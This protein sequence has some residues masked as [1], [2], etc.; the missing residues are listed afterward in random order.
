M[1]ELEP[2]AY[3]CIRPLASGPHLAL[4]VDAVAAGN[5]PAMAWC[6]DAA[7]PSAAFLWDKAHCYFLLGEPHDDAFNRSVRKLVRD[8]L[9]PQAVAHGHA[10][11][12]VY[13]G[14]EGW[15]DQI[16]ELFA[17][18]DLAERERVFQVL[19][20]VAILDWRKRVPDGYDVRQIDQRLL[21]AAG[22]R[23]ATGLVYEIETGWPSLAHFLRAGFGFCLLGAGEI[24][25][26][27]TAE[28]ASTGKCGVGVETTVE[29]MR[30]GFATLTASAFVEHAVNRGIMPHWDSWKAN[31]P[32]LA[33]AQKVGFRPMCE[34]RVWTGRFR[35][36]M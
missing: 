11:L 17:G 25:T 8:Q 14:P 23:N 12:K 18:A 10:F 36:K 24:I 31:L 32:S 9:V 29:H 19:D 21:G 3:E 27:C 5:S 1:V 2:R 16:G 15:R 30:Q 35:E 26:W 13:Y 6:D 34:Y 20:H 4:A 7:Q 33:V 28:Y 22:L